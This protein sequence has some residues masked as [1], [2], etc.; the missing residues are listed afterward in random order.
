M[1]TSTATEVIEPLSR[2]ST[3]RFNESLSWRAGKPLTIA[4]LLRRLQL[5]AQELQG[6][7]QEDIP[8][9]GFRNVPGELVKPH[10]LAHKDKGVKAWTAHCL[11]DILRLFAPDAPYTGMQ[12]RVGTK[13][14]Y[15]WNV[16]SYFLGHLQ[17]DHL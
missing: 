3:L 6:L 9:E 10:L 8:R 16:H 2:M 5:L 15:L 11:V 7:E 14:C 12:L 17:Y 13:S 1:P 4:D